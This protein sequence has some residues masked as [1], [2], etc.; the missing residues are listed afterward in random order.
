MKKGVVSVLSLLIGATV[1]TVGAG[2]IM[3]DKT[4]EALRL[5]NKHLVLF[6]MMNQWVKVKQ[7]G[8]NLSSYFEKNEYKKIAV[9]GMSYAGETLVEEL[10]NSNIEIAYGIDQKA[11][12]LYSEIDIVSVDD[13]LEEVD[14]VV[15]TAISF[16]DEIEEKLSEKL[17]CPILSLENILYE[18]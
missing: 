3:G 1:G 6:L 5:S 9:Y 14:A 11:S 13:N 4:D 10:K 16:F 7:E 8:K 18:V 15:V 2:K 17:S 12:S